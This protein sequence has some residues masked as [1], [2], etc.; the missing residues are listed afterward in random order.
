[1]EFADIDELAAATHQANLEMHLCGGT[2]YRGGLL[3]LQLDGVGAQWGFHD[4]PMVGR[5]QVWPEG[6]FLASWSGGPSRANGVPLG[7]GLVYYPPGSEHQARTDAAMSWVSFR[8]A[9]LGGLAAALAPGLEL[10]PGSALRRVE[11]PAEALATVWRI[12]QD[13]RRLADSGA[14]PL[15]GA[16]AGA[17]LREELGTALIR[18]LA[19]DRSPRRRE[20]LPACSALVRRTEELLRAGAYQPVQVSELCAALGVGEVRLREAFQ[21]VYGLSPARYLR[22]RRLNLVRRALQATRPDE[23]TVSDA[24]AGQGFFQLGRFA[25]EFRALFGELPSQSRRAS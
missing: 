22:L 20:S 11:D 16:A 4:V 10:G 2:R 7:S 14:D 15:P 5:G 13:L 19:A 6:A 24:A 9:D 12:L 1:V 23:L 21:R 3:D 25:G 17:S 8:V 18:A